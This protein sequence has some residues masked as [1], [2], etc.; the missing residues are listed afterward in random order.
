MKILNGYLN[1]KKG[2]VLTIGNFD[3]IHKGHQ[4]IL[5]KNVEISKKYNLNSAVIT[6]D[7][8]PNEFFKKNKS[9]FKL[10]NKNTKIKEI[11][12]MGINY[13]IFI[14]FTKDFTKLS[15]EK[16]IKKIID[17]NPQFI[18]VGYNFRFG[19]KRK[20]NVNLLQK[21]SEKYSY[22]LEVISRVLNKNKKVIN[23][24]LI[25]KKIK[26]GHYNNVKDMLGRNWLLEGKI[27]KGS[28]RGKSL[29]YPT[30][31]FFI[32][33]YILP[34]KGVYVTKSFFKNNKKAYYG[35]ANI[36]NRPT[37]NEKKVFFENH[38]FEIKKNFYGK[39]IFV[40][41]LAFLRKEKKFENIELLKKQINKDILLAKRFI[42]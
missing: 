18:V 17:L 4:K 3:G 9:P 39:D 12:K 27:I 13:L 25:R 33:D 24:T 36:G 34:M 15:P 7:P 11:K 40:E 35:I 32:K 31:N 22:K 29:G 10:T 6:F 14:K 42:K 16:F 37:F 1:L 21:F 26:T 5:K 41:L 8:H 38:F 19:Y 30:A 28:G 23:S 2:T 20:G